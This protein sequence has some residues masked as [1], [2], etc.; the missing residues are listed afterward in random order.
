MSITLDEDAASRWKNQFANGSNS[1]LPSWQ[2]PGPKTAS[3]GGNSA[4]GTSIK[5]KFESVLSRL[6]WKSVPWPG[7]ANPGASNQA[8]I[9]NPPG[10]SPPACWRESYLCV[11]R[12]WTSA[13]ETKLSTID[14]IDTLADDYAFF[15]EA[16]IVL[17]CAQGNWLQ[18]FFSWKS[19]TH[20]SL[21][22]VESTPPSNDADLRLSQI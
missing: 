1:I 12:C 8:R 20:V 19:F 17:S 15:N 10:V 7:K 18:R 14:S 9:S 16:R 6:S 21:S 3:T 22:K 13:V 11:D 5:K 4:T 2:T